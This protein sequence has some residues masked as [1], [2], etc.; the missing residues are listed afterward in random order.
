LF[1]VAYVFGSRGEDELVVKLVWRV[2]LVAELPA[3]MTRE[4][5][6]ARLERSDEPDLAD[7]GLRLVEAKQLTAALQAEMVSTQ[8]TVVGERCRGCEA[9]G[10]V[11]T[12]KGYYPATFRSLFGDVP[13]RVRRLLAC[14]CQGS[15][16]PRV[17]PCSTWR[18]QPWRLSW[19]M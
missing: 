2:N 13:V 12:R 17:S 5:E 18:R 9:C 8:V 4:V 15:E 10:C 14:P 16:G 11:L 7:L 3:G 6:V 19:R 1:P